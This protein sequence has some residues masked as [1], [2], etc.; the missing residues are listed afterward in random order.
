MYLIFLPFS[1]NKPHESILPIN[2]GFI[3][4]NGCDFVEFFIDK[5][6]PPLNCHVLATWLPLAMSKHRKWR[7]FLKSTCK[8]M[9]N[10]P[11]RVCSSGFCAEVYRSHSEI[12]LRNVR[13]INVMSLR[14]NMSPCTHMKVRSKCFSLQN[15]I[16]AFRIVKDC[17]CC[18]LYKG[19]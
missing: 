3:Y 15:E 1:S 18:T 4:R 19:D 13:H 6:C 5:Y 7:M 9:A 8:H 17:H 12:H 10:F 14:A 2:L 11:C 16:P